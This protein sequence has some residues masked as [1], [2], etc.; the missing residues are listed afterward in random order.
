LKEEVYQGN[1]GFNFVLYLTPQKGLRQEKENDNLNDD[2]GKLTIENLQ[3]ES[4]PKN[5]NEGKDLISEE[6]FRKISEIS[7]AKSYKSYKSI[8]L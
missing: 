3:N 5:L 4:Q 7:P 6:L 2:L 1:S 8:S